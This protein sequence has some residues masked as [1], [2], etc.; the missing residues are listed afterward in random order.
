VPLSGTVPNF[1]AQVLINDYTLREYIP[2]NT[3]YVYRVSVENGTL[4]EGK[5][6]Y[7]L[8]L[9]NSD[10]Q[11]IFQE[12]LTVY[13]SPDA[14]KL[15]SYRDE[16]DR[17]YLARKNTPAMIADRERKKQETLQKLEVL[18]EHYYY[19]EKFEPFTIKVAF[20]TGPQST[21]KYALH[22]EETLKKL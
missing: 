15:Q 6:T 1:T 21:E 17:E 2:G 3:L 11:T 19:N 20:M 5:N 18:D 12:T 9:K 13:Y 8:N 16:V 4:K 7:T 14:T 10:S 22:V